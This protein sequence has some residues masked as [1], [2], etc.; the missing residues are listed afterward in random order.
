VG[1]FYPGRPVQKERN[2]M[3][4]PGRELEKLRAIITSAC[5][6]LNHAQENVSVF[7]RD[8]HGPSADCYVLLHDAS[9][10]FCEAVSQSHGETSERRWSPALPELLLAHPEKCRETLALVESKEFHELSHFQYTAA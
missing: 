4:D 7:T 9:K 1:R 3:T 5:N 8:L 2:F 6:M 10:M